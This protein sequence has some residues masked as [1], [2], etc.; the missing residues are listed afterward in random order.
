MSLKVYQEYSCLKLHFETVYDYQRYNGKSKQFNEKTYKK[1]K[2]IWC[3]ENIA[4]KYPRDSLEYLVFCFGHVNNIWIGDLTSPEIYAEYFKYR[5][6]Y[7]SPRYSLE[8]IIDK[9]LKENNCTFRELFR[10]T[11]RCHPLLM[12]S[13]L[14][15]S[16][17]LDIFIILDS[18]LKFTNTWNIYLNDDPLYISMMRRIENYKSFITVDKSKYINEIKERLK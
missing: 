17:Y 14:T 2:D 15:K 5:T 16:C 12:V 11:H 13:I 4:R 7:D 18:I 9:L 10:I 1:R 6:F 3:F 8:R